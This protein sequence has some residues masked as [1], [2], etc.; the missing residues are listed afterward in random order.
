M[1]K[2]PDIPFGHLTI[3]ADQPVVI[4]AEIGINHEGNVNVCRQMVEAAAASGADAVKLQTIDADENYV[5]GTESHDLFK[6]S[7]LTPE[8]TF[9]IFEL[10]NSLGVEALTTV[11]D[12]ATL[13]WVE[14]L[15]PAAH[16]IS[17]GLLTH[18]P[19]IAKTAKTGRTMLMSTGMAT[20]NEITEAVDTARSNGAASLGIFQCTSNYPAPDNSLNLRVMGYLRQRHGC[21]TGFSDH[22]SGTDA[23][24]LA[25]AAGAMFIEKHFTLDR[26]RADY[27]HR[28]SLEPDGFAEMV[29]KVRQASEMLG[30]SEKS[31]SLEETA[32]RLKYQRCL[33]ARTGIKCG[34]VLTE[35]NVAVKRP[36]PEKR[37][38][39]PREFISVLGKTTNVDLKADDPI[40]IQ[41]IED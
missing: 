36:L 23:A 14:D 28:L 1:N 38:L 39:P 2:V 20:D 3:G 12:A 18:I 32:N 13:K 26:T 33:V 40:T 4:I 25:A 24:A 8:E 9:E 35:A 5:V 30:A 22:T 37:G 17:S 21:P 16:K 27:D 41:A 11:G 34:E 7:A 10:A 15:N 29:G 6:Y 19:V 31:L